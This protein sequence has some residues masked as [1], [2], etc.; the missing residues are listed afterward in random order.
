MYDFRYMSLEH[1]LLSRYPSIPINKKAYLSIDVKV[2]A[3][4]NSASSCRQE[5]DLWWY[6]LP[7]GVCGS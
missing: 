6:L 4:A 1:L 3:E 7:G 2:G 5:R